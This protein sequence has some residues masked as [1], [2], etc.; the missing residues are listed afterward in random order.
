MSAE[1]LLSRLQNVR[2]RGN[3]KWMASCPCHTDNTPSL[4][5][6]DNAGKILLHCFSQQCT[7]SEICDAIGINISDLFPPSDDYDASKPHQRRYYYDSQHVLE[8]LAEETLTASV[9]ISE[10]MDSGSLYQEDIE[11]IALAAGRIQ[12]ALEYTRR[13]SV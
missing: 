6:A 2:R 12:S 8:S 5:I 11:R 3:G 7:P 9:I 10:L 13:I 1:N 4:A